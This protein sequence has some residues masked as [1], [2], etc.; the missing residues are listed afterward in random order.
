MTYKV[1]LFSAA[2][3]VDL[4]EFFKDDAAA[5]A[6]MQAQQAQQQQ[7]RTLNLGSMQSDLSP[8]ASADSPCSLSASFNHQS[9][10]RDASPQQDVKPMLPAQQQQEPYLSMLAASNQ[11]AMPQATAAVQM[12]TPASLMQYQQLMMMQNAATMAALA[13]GQ[14]QQLLQQMQLAPLMGLV[15]VKQAGK[16]SS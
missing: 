3:D 15:Q 2:A 9:P 11:N 10:S 6:P 12:A 8:N 5:C 13:P 1:H 16:V 4:Y 7:A 14:Q